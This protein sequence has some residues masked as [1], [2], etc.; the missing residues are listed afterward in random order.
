LKF[1]KEQSKRADKK[2]NTKVAK[3]MVSP[4]TVAREFQISKESTK[5]LWNNF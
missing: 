3:K 2:K 1:K 5:K 4:P